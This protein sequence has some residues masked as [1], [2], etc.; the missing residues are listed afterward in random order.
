MHD[1]SGFSRIAL[2]VPVHLEL[3]GWLLPLLDVRNQCARQRLVHNFDPHDM[4]RVHSGF[5]PN[6]GG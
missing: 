5:P 3:P 4:L 2:Q 1:R 6:G